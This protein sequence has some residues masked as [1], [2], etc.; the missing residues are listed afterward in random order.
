MDYVYDPIAQVQSWSRPPIDDVGYIQS[1]DLLLRDD[2]FIRNVVADMERTRFTGWRNHLG[3]WKN[4]MGLSTTINKDVCDYGSGAGVEALIYA[5]TGNRVHL[6][7]IVE[8][9]L[10]LAERVLTIHGYTPAS[11]TLI[12]P[13]PAN[14]N[15]VPFNDSSIDVFHCSGV[16]HHTPH[17]IKIM[18]N[19]HRVLRPVGEARLMLYSD[20]GWRTYI[21]TEPPDNVTADPDFQKFV[22]IFDQVGSYADW[23]NEA[24]LM[25][26]FGHLFDVVRF[27]YLTPNQR[28]CAAI[29]KPRDQER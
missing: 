20:L 8:T 1:Q 4:I 5:R 24:K 3:L 28:Y 13:E 23:Y 7:D 19:V 17:A 27:E 21:G 11:V 26:L 14:G 29:L 12:D 18:T 22:R 10:L 15:Y 2:E 25:Q 6:V 16:L 9:N